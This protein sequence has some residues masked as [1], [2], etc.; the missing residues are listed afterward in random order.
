MVFLLS[1]TLISF[2]FSSKGSFL[3]CLNPDSLE[4][5]EKC[6]LE[7]SLS[8]SVPG[9]RFQLER[10]GYFCTDLDSIPDKLVF[11]RTVPLRDS[12][13]KIEKSMKE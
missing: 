9:E 2:N 1:K 10:L 4:V 11:N 12:W 8:K 5:L 13:A 3:D 6:Y 7:P